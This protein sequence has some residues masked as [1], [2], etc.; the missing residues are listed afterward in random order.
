MIRTILVP[1]DG[2]ELAEGALPQARRLARL[3][4]ATLVLVRVV[5]LLRRQDRHDDMGRAE[6]DAW[7]P[8]AAGLR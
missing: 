3:S 5:C 8:M 4:G 2:S 1:L 6:A 7:V